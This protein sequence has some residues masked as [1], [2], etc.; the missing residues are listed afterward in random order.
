MKRLLTILAILAVLVVAAAVLFGIIP[1][2]IDFGL[3]TPNIP[4]L[5]LTP[6]AETGMTTEVRAMPVRTGTVSSYIK[7]TGNLEAAEEASL[8]F[9]IDGTV[10]EIFVERGDIVEEG[11]VLARLDTTDVELA[12]TKAEISLKKAEASL[13]KIV[14][15]PDEDDVASDRASLTSAQASYDALLEGQSEEEVTVAAASL[16]KAEVSLQEAQWAYDKV[17]FKGDVGASSQAATLQDATIDYQTAL[18]NYQMTVDDASEEEILSAV[19]KVASAEATLYNLL[20]GSSDEDIASAEADV[21]TA[22]LNLEE[23]Q[24]ELEQASLTARFSGTVTEVNGGVGERVETAGVIDL[25]DL[26]V[27]HI[28]VPVDE[29]DLPEVVVGQS[30]IVVLDALSDVNITGQVT[31]I[32]PSPT[33]TDIVTYEV[34]VTLDEQQEGAVVGMTSNVSIET[35]RH[36]NVVVVPST[37]V[38]VDDTTGETYVNKVEEDGTTTKTVIELGLREDDLIEVLSGLEE[39]DRISL[40]VLTTPGSDDEDEAGTGMMPMGIMSGGGPPPG[41][42]GGGGGDRRPQ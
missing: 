33:G 22:Q 10:A 11:D 8:S 7:A 3:P 39:G 40:P 42:G 21:E 28:D 20:E 35:E 27:L 13:A 24:R 1:T 12:V 2:G 34:T 14:A 41:D 29:I 4:F 17:A 31:A 15:E 19:S 30:A 23:A 6:E 9:D 26:S 5:G 18:A 16:R 25:A 38:A 36:E 32:A 37:M